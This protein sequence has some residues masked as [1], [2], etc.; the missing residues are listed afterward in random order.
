MS[1][2]KF[3]RIWCIQCMFSN[4]NGFKLIIKC[5]IISATSSNIWKWNNVLLNPW[6]KK[7]SKGVFENISNLMN[8][9]IQHRVFG[10]QLEQD[11]EIYMPTQ[12][13]LVLL[14]FAL[15]HFADI[16]SFTNWRFV[17]TL[18]RASLSAPFFPTAFA[19]FVSL[20]HILVIFSISQTF[21]LLL[22][23]LWWSVISNLWC[24]Y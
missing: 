20:C 22:H 16:V 14:C 10:T 17:A 6:V 7:K 8:M 21:S 3:K 11:L 23:R 13:Y 12:A 15:L 18:S 24:Y 5:R 19:H 9:K 2:N 1:L 4:N